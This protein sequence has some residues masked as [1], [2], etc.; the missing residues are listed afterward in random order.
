[1]AGPGPGAGGR[2]GFRALSSTQVEEK[3]PD[4]SYS[5]N[6]PTTMPA[7]PPPESTVPDDDE[8]GE[9]RDSRGS[10]FRRLRRA[11]WK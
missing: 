10:G 4:Y 6:N 3:H 2:V 9:E 8:G 5:S 1:M 7:M 11:C